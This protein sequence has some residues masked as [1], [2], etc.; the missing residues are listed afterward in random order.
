MWRWIALAT[1]LWGKL[2]DPQR[3]QDMAAMALRAD[4]QLMLQGCKVCWTYK[5]LDTLTSMGLLDG[6]IGIPS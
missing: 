6:V 5:L 4:V 3:E 2:A 1:R